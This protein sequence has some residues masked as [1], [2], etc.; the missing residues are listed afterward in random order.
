LSS[1]I[2]HI[3][4]FPDEN[5][6]QDRNKKQNKT[7]HEKDELDIYVFIQKMIKTKHYLTSNIFHFYIIYHFF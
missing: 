4:A 5:G 7:S 3:N 2:H 1:K 6:K